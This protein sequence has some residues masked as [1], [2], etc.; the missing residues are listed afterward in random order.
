MCRIRG[1]CVG[2]FGQTQNVPD[3]SD[4]CQMSIQSV[5]RDLNFLNFLKIFTVEI[6]IGNTWEPEDLCIMAFE[7]SEL[8]DLGGPGNFC[9]GRNFY[10]NFIF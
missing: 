3:A 7:I 2:D 1:C 9:G 10:E 8:L 6:S 5:P 4:V